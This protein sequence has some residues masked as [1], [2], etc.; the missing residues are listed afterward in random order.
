MKC[1]TIYLSVTCLS[2]V[3]GKPS[4]VQGVGWQRLWPGLTLSSYC[5]ILLFV[6]LSFSSLQSQA[7]RHSAILWN[8]CSQGDKW[9]A[10]QIHKHQLMNPM[11]LMSSPSRPDSQGIE[12]HV[13]SFSKCVI[14]VFLEGITA[15]LQGRVLL[16][17]GLA[18][19]LSSSIGNRDI[20]GCRSPSYQ[21]VFCPSPTSAPEG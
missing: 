5:L 10:S 9:T 19:T 21:H 18:L 4:V 20:L 16:S 17:L 2:P 7:N 13:Q 12:H 14:W 8:C 11:W 1:V 15:W 6:S 3:E